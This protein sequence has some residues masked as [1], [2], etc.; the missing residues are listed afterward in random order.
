MKVFPSPFKKLLLVAMVVGLSLTGCKKE[1]SWH[2]D[3]ITGSFPALDFTMTLARD[4]KT[5][6][7]RDYRGKIVMLYFGYTFCPDICPTTLLDMTT[8][9]KNLG[10]K[11]KDVRFLF[12][13][14]DP[15]RD[16]LD[17]LKKYESLFAPQVDAL[18]PTADQL[19]NLAKRYR[20][21]YSVTPK[22]KT[23]P[24]YDVVHSSA[25]YVFDRSGAARLIIPTLAKSGHIKGVT[26]DI[27]R[28][29]SE[30][31]QGNRWWRELRRIF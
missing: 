2:A 16:T 6:I 1:Q 9:L 25:I 27:E 10:P 26:A 11:A 23:H 20:I 24:D 13:S 4:G 12:V 31:T 14:V 8:I 22:T 17:I 30:K 15:D 5:V 28:L 19:A 7:A 21:A 18:R 29:L 3:N